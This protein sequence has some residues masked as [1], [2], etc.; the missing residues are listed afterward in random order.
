MSCRTLITSG[1]SLRRRDM[2]KSFSI[3]QIL[4]RQCRSTAYIRIAPIGWCVLIVVV[5]RQRLLLYIGSIV[6]RR[7]MSKPS[8]LLYWK[9]PCVSARIRRRSCSSTILALRTLAP[10]L[11]G[12]LYVG[13]IA[14]AGATLRPRLWLRGRAH[15]YRDAVGA[16]TWC[17]WSSRYEE[18]SH[19]HPFGWRVP[20]WRAGASSWRGLVLA[21]G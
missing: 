20:M 3:L 2:A 19:T 12:Y 4:R 14:R 6:L 7:G 18:N 10:L 15:S 8:V 9:I 21:N 16:R 11:T 1:F 17:W 13:N 5:G